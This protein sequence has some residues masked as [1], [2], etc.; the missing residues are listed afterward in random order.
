MGWGGVDLGRGVGEGTVR[1]G[2]GWDK[3]RISSFFFTECMIFF[4]LFVLDVLLSLYIF[5]LLF[6]TVAAID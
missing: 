2:V 5:L 4:F 6:Y 3:M 1:G